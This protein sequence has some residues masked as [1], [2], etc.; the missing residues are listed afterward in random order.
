MKMIKISDLQQV[1]GKFSG[2]E[3]FPLRHGWLKK[4]YDAVSAYDGNA[5]SDLFKGENA[6]VRFGVGRNMAFSIRHWSLTCGIIQELDDGVLVPT[7]LGDF[8]FGAKGV[9]PY[10]ESFAS[11]WLLHWELVSKS[12]HIATTWYWV[13][14]HLPQQQFDRDAL[15]DLLAIVIEDYAWKRASVATLKRDVDCF[16][17][18]YAPKKSKGLNTEETIESIFAELSIILPTSASTYRFNRGERSSLPDKVFVWCMFE[19]WRSIDSPNIL[20]VEQ[21]TYDPGSP[22]RVFKIDESAL[23]DRVMRI[24]DT[25]EGCASWIDTA[26]LRQVHI[27]KSPPSGYEMLRSAYEALAGERS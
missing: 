4:A 10:L 22:G 26:G 2:H 25:S 5:R 17:R 8:L 6:I 18:C 23:V 11:I 20:S 13:F 15:V 19:Y 16:L 24:H 7:E 21:L 12:P 1:K 9:D 27:L 14:N 3:T